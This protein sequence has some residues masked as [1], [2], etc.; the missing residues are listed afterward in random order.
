MKPLRRGRIATV[1]HEFDVEDVE[2][3]TGQNTLNGQPSFALNVEKRGLTP[4]GQPFVAGV[5]VK[6]SEQRVETPRVDSKGNIEIG[7]T[8]DVVAEWS[9]W[10]I[11][12]DEFAIAWDEWAFKR[13][14]FELPVWD[15]TEQELRLNAFYDS[16]SLRDVSS[17]GFRARQDRASKGTVHGNSVDEDERLGDELPD[18]TY[19]NELRFTHWWSRAGREV[20]AY[21]AASGYVELYT[22]SDLSTG[23]YLDWVRD[24]LLAH[25]EDAPEDDEEDDA[26]QT[27]EES[28]AADVQEDDAEE[29]S[30]DVREFV[31]EEIDAEITA[32]SDPSVCDHCGGEREV[33]QVRGFAFCVA[34]RNAWE[35]GD[36]DWVVEWRGGD[37]AA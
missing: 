8:D 34:C 35:N 12:P 4:D 32:P 31:Q 15:W 19:L 20:K 37:D 10:A 27:L 21:L 16:Q 3:V 11:V 5:M 33:E 29:F 30:E 6:R 26:Q 28:A 2:D 25:L 13:L 9:K 1:T 17:V 23:G 18:E 36:A 22:P 7:H 24:E 14:R